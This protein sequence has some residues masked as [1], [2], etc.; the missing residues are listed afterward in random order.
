[1]EGALLTLAAKGGID[2]E[3]AEQQYPRIAE[4]PFDAAYKLM[5]TFHHTL[6]EIRVCI[7]GAPEVILEHC[8]TWLGPTGEEPFSAVLRERLVEQNAQLGARGLRVLAVAVRTLS[9]AEFCPPGDLFAFL[10]GLTFIGLI[11]LLDP[12]RAEAQAAIAVCHQAGIAVKMITGDHKGTAAAIAQ[13]LGLAGQVVSGAELDRLNSDQLRE[14]VESIAVFARVA[15]EHKVKIVQALRGRGH[16]VAMTGDGVNDA[17]ALKI[18]D[19]GVA[20]SRTG[21]EVAKEA[22]IMVLTND[23]FATIVEAVQ[24]GRTIYDNLLKFIRFQLSTTFGAILTV[25]CAPL[26]GLPEPFT[27]IQIL[28]IAMIMDGPPAIALG[29]DPARPGLMTEPP[30]ARHAVILPLWRLGHIFTFGALMVVGT[31]GALFYGLQGARPESAL[32]LAFTTFV[33]FQLCN[34][35]NARVETGS[36]FTAHFFSNRPLWLALGGVVGLHVVAVHWSVA[37]A[38]F[39]TTDLSLTEW[40]IAS[41]IAISIL[42]LEE[43]RKVAGKALTGR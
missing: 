2:R 36:A 4:I 21:T 40:G 9:P 18:A 37:Q 17:P 11:G 25:F 35:F 19:I 29:V 41:G 20:M 13:D 6:S 33:L 16:V 10:R 24:E 15:P 28:W 42:L 31:L 32:T 26:I 22:A 39:Q 38:L 12:P 27:P 1:M 7:K 8:T 3:T 23:N 43:L 30:R 5:A 34:V 14:A